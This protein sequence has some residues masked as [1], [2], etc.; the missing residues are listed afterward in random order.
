MKKGKNYKLLYFEI[1]LKTLANV[2]RNLPNTHV[3]AFDCHLQI[4]NTTSTAFIL[5]ISPY[6][7]ELSYNGPIA[8]Y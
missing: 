2:N 1:C 5:S 4:P 7:N 6:E 8:V 3:I